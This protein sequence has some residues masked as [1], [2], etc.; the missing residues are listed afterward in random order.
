MALQVVFDA[1]AFVE[2]STTF[3]RIVK[4]SRS[5]KGAAEGV[6]KALGGAARANQALG[7]AMSEVASSGGRKLKPALDESEDGAKRAAKSVA[8]ASSVFEA[9]GKVGES[10]GNVRKVFGGITSDAKGFFNTLKEFGAAK[11]FTDLFGG[12][13]DTIKGL[14][15]E[16]SKQ[17]VPIL[18]PAIQQL[19]NFLSEPGKREMI[20][21][22]V[23]GI[24]RGFVA[25]IK[26]LGVA[27]YA[28]SIPILNFVDAIGGWETVG[29]VIAALYGVRLVVAVN[30]F[31]TAVS[32]ALTK[33]AAFAAANPLVAI[34]GVIAIAALLI[35]AN[36]EKVKSFFDNLDQHF[37]KLFGGPLGKIFAFTTKVAF[38][39]LL[40][41]AKGLKKL[42]D[43]VLSPSAD[44]DAEADAGADATTGV[45]A[46]GSAATALASARSTLVQR[47]ALGDGQKRGEILVR[48]E[49]TPPGTVVETTNNTEINIEA[50]VSFGKSRAGGNCRV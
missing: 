32:V 33:T 9:F 7:R 47:G 8:T 39:P 21:R 1:T 29:L 48:F 30:S 24:V 23:V 14:V 28:A 27:A 20:L 18:R 10:F 15:H 13:T 25:T 22:A 35:I 31:A 34:A 40:T 44:A 6:E 46:S 50:Q 16:L 4:V 12:V 49:N 43:V 17:L 37:K 41:L 45:S 5:L 26:T 36:W 19:Q 11:E 42:G 3:R 2:V 38:F